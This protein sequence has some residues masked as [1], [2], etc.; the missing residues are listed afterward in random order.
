M[1]QAKSQLPSVQ[2][3]AAF[4]GAMHVRQ[5]TPQR[6][7]SSL[8]THSSPQAW[9]PVAQT[10]SCEVVLQAPGCGHCAAESQPDKHVEPRQ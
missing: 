4:A 10:H 8:V 1:L 6:L 3:G 2:S 5:V 9:R 7:T